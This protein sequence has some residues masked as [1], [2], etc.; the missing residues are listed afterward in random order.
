MQLLRAKLVSFFGWRR[1]SSRCHFFILFYHC[2]YFI[3]LNRIAGDLNAPPTRRMFEVGGEPGWMPVG[4]R[5]LGTQVSVCCCCC[6]CLLLLSLLRI[7]KLFVSFLKKSHSKTR[8]RPFTHVSLHSGGNFEQLSGIF[9]H[10]FTAIDD[11]EIKAKK[12]K[13]RKFIYLYI[14]SSFCDQSLFYI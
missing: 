5:G 8:S 14:R 1:A 7:H 3:F 4:R 12:K 2:Y 9:P 10:C 6:S 11:S 13:T